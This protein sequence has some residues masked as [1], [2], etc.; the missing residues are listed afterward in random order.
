MRDQ[1]DLPPVPES[2]LSRLSRLQLTDSVP[3]ENTLFPKTFGWRWETVMSLYPIES[4]QIH[5][6]LQ[7]Q[8]NRV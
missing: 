5:G 2:W 4:P 8:R 3:K 6:Q 7:C 1:R